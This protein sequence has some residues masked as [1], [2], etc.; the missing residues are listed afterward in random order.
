MANTV[1][2][3]LVQDGPRN[4]VVLVTGTLDTSNISAAGTLG[5]ASTGTTTIGTPNISFTAGG[6]VP[7][8]G[9]SVTGTGIP[10][11]AYIRSYTATTAVLSAN[12]TATGTL[13]TFSLV[14]GSIVLID[15]AKLSQIGGVEGLANRVALDHIDY[16]IEDLLNAYLYWDATIPDVAANLV[17]RG[18]IDFTGQLGNSETAGTTGIVR[19]ATQGWGAGAILSFTLQIGFIKYIK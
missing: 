9:Q 7:T 17:G 5:T 15:P 10:A 3:K 16:I 1:S 14:A 12:A 6:L 4:A 8:V 11:G 13:L 18:E 19:L 2:T